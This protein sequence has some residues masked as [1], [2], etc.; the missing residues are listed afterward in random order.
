M[1]QISL[2]I[3]QSCSDCPCVLRSFP[4]FTVSRIVLDYWCIQPAWR[5]NHSCI[6]PRYRIFD[7][8]EHLI[9][10]KNILLFRGPGSF[11]TKFK[12]GET[13][14]LV[15]ACRLISP[16]GYEEI[17]SILVDQWRPSIWDQMQWR[18][19][20]RSPQPMSTAVHMEPKLTLEI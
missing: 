7:A 11:K 1:R 19:S 16:G 17:S 3:S 12:I 13:V 6:Y 9:P 20:C 8:G 15:K 5:K 10:R 2:E 4:S 14:E 18:G